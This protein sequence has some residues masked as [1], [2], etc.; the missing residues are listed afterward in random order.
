MRWQTQVIFPAFT[1]LVHRRPIPGLVVIFTGILPVCQDEEGLASVLCGRYSIPALF[2]HHDTEIG[3]VGME[4]R[5][6]TR[7]GF[8]K[9]YPSCTAF[10]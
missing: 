7:L 10:C 4:L 1:R 5:L 8:N 9:P 6:S 3:H 2:Y